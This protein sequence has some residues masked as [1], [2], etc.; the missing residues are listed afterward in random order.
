MQQAIIVG[1][2]IVGAMIAYELTQS[3]FQVTVLDRQP[4]AQAATGAALGVL[5]GVIS[6]KTKGRAWTMRQLSTARYAKLMP[7]LEAALGRALPW[8]PQGILKLGFAAEDKAKWQALVELRQQQGWR[9]ELWSPDQVQARCPQVQSPVQA[10]LYSPQDCQVDPTALTLALVEAAQRQGASFELDVEVQRLSANG[11]LQTSAGDLGADWIVIAAGLGSAPL[12][13][14][15]Q[16]T[17]APVLG[18]AIRVKTRQPLGQPQFQPVITGHDIHLV[19][20]GNSE[21][22]VGATVEFDP[23]ENAPI[24][25][26]LEA[27]WQGAVALWP[28]LQT[29]IRLASW[30]GLRPRPVDRPAPIVEPLA[31]H[32]RVLLATGHYRNGVLLAPATAQIIRELI[33]PQ[34]TA[35]R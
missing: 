21:Y 10:G 2:G 27:V 9:L 33:A 25:E 6:Q 14:I 1:C 8:N 32:P 34:L 28:G 16:I 13:P 5:M 12:L 17:L 23:A 7:E 3:G 26:Q 18:Q 4:P 15:P 31:G 29:A 30:S 24:P 11:R 35:Q 19:P 22:W 20:L